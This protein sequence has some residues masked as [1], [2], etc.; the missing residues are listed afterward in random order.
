MPEPPANM[1]LVLIE[2]VDTFG[3]S[4]EWQ[5]ICDLSPT[6]LCCRS[7]GWLAYDGEDCKVIIPHLSKSHE[8]APPQ[9]CGDMTIPTCAIRSI[10]DLH[11]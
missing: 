3:C 1:R 2:W 7:V 6:V 10:K 11:A 5:E 9:G 4:T 8:S